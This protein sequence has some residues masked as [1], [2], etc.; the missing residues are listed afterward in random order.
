MAPQ[1]NDFESATALKDDPSAAIFSEGWEDKKARIKKASPF[2]ALPGWDLLSVVVKAGCDMRQ[3]QLACQL[4]EEMHDIWNMSGLPIWVAP[5]RILVAGSGEGGLMETARNAIS[6]HSIKKAALSCRRAVIDESQPPPPFT[7]RDYYIKTFGS[8]D[9][10]GFINARD[11]F[12]KSLVGYSLVT[13]LLQLRDRHNGNI[14]VDAAGHVIHI[15]FGFMLA[16]SPGGGTYYGLESAP[17]KLTAEYI[18]LLGGLYSE[19]FAAFKDLVYQGFMA[20][21]RHAD[22]LLLLLEISQKDSNLACFGGAGPSVIA[23]MR[24]RLQP[25]LSEYQVKLFV[26]RLVTGSAYNLF[27]RLYDSFQYYSNGI[28]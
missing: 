15:D 17:F 27:T 13:Y 5:L 12:M 23:Q 10:D 16:V 22:R 21:R 9:S 26:D 24:Q 11:A 1:L 3:E 2:G 25:G 6:L 20:L 7:L 8:P 4:I 19:P 18:D 14:L 28:L